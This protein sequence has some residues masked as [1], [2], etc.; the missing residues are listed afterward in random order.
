M[1]QRV[2]M[3]IART[4]NVQK[5]KKKLSKQMKAKIRWN[6]W[7]LACI[8]ETFTKTTVLPQLLD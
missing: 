3:N 2:P 6:Y 4:K 1:T 8:N 5:P 7:P